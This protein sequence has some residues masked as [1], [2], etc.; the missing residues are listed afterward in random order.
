MKKGKYEPKGVSASAQGV[1]FVFQIEKTQGAVAIG[2]FSGEKE[3]QRIPVPESCRFGRLYSV[4]LETVPKEADSYCY[5]V[6]E[7]PVLDFYAK[8]VYGMKAYGEEKNSLRYRLSLPEYDWEGDAPLQRPYHETVLYGIH[9]RGF[10]HHSSSGV[11][12]KGTFA[13]IVEKLPYLKELGITAIE[14][15]PAY[16]FDEWE[17]DKENV[18]YQEQEKFRINYWGFKRGYYYAPKSA[19]AFS[20]DAVME[21]KDMVKAL[22]SAGIEVLMQFYFQ[23]SEMFSE[24]AD[25]LRFWISEYHIDGFH[26]IGTEIPVRALTLD[27][28]LQGGKLIFTDLSEQDLY[29]QQ[30]LV[31]EKNAAIWKNA[32]TFDMRRALKGDEGSMEAMLFWLRDNGRDAASIHTIAGYEGFTLRDLVSYEQKHNEANNEE[33]RDGNDY[34]ASWNCGVE[35]V[36]RKKSIRQL[37]LGQMRNALTLVFLSQGTPYLQSG[38]EFGQ[39][40][41]G[42]NNPYCQDNETTWLDWKLLRTNRTFY[43]FVRALLAFRME[44]GVFHGEKALQVMDYLSVGCPDISFHGKEAWK[45]DTEAWNRHAGVLYCGK[46]ARQKDGKTDCDFYTAYNMHWE[47]HEFALPKL[48]KGLVW[49]LCLDTALVDGGM[50]EME[51]EEMYALP[52][53]QILTKERS[54]RV[55]CSVKKEAE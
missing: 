1:Q 44:H 50:Q 24:I 34:N 39:T 3:L 37:R 25:I 45:P 33:N 4:I 23:K 55:Y 36:T 31:H 15:M 18:P 19:Y 13:G 32:F 47:E 51:A 28:F 26:L 16:E 5:Y 20:K 27:A 54:I 14:L 17:A 49:K 52:G 11:R 40:Q 29:P 6:D 41:G 21:F 42:N 7:K 53:S 2:I 35:G 10:T 8:E 48:K 9:V 38:D 22:H 43:E 46:Y 12:K 30:K